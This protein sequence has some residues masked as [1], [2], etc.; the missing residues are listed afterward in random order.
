MEYNGCF[1]GRAAMGSASLLQGDG[2]RC[3]RFQGFGTG[4]DGVLVGGIVDQH[5]P[6]VVAIRSRSTGRKSRKSLVEL[7]EQVPER[8]CC[9]AAGVFRRICPS[10]SKVLLS[11]GFFCA[12]AR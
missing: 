9:W 1:H 10:W 8:V 4:F 5:F 7:H 12:W 11:E 6:A 2:C 3:F